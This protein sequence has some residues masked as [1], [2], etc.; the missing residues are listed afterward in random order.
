MAKVR[1]PKYS[2]SPTVSK[3][4]KFSVEPANYKDYYPC[5]QLSRLDIN[6]R[7]GLL[8]FNECLKFSF[9]ENLLN[10]VSENSYN[11][12]YNVLDDLN[13]REFD[14]ICDF[15]QKL[16]QGISEDI[17]KHCMELI[18]K[19][20]NRHVFINKI[21]PKLKSFE[22]QTWEEIERETHHKGKSKHHTVDIKDI[23]RD[24]QKRLEE[25]KCNDIEQLF[26]LRLEGDFRIWG[27][28]KTNCLQIIWVDP[29][30]EVYPVSKQ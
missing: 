1:V 15:V 12:I 5:W 23:C 10:H 13:S 17:P 8:S 29:K 14:G 3:A 9:S 27:I 30:H 26:S 20:L 21:L 7:W 22:S 19:E 28:R 25:L 2:T 11:E 4:A 24:A 16:H 18:V 6:G